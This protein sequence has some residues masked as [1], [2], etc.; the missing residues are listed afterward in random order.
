MRDIS[1]LNKSVKCQSWF[2]PMLKYSKSTCSLQH[3]SSYTLTLPWKCKTIRRYFLHIMLWQRRM[4]MMVF[5]LNFRFL[6]KK[7]FMSFFASIGPMMASETL[8]VFNKCWLNKWVNR[9][10]SDKW[11]TEKNVS[12]CEWVLQTYFIFVLKNTI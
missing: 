6:D 12:K 7:H 1:K 4:S 11:M 3:D 8:T 9:L 2:K 10:L 5:L